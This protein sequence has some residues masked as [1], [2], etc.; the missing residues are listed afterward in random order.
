M[1][2]LA[3][4]S[5]NHCV[6]WWSTTRVI[7]LKLIG[8]RGKVPGYTNY[9]RTTDVIDVP[10]RD[11]YVIGLLIPNDLWFIVGADKIIRELTINRELIGPQSLLEAR[12]SGQNRS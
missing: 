7:D 5:E 9:F 1:R 11:V 10:G 6:T 2:G 8:I 3:N 12:T 4:E